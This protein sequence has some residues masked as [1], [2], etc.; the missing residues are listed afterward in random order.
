RPFR[1]LDGMSERIAAIRR[2]EN[3]AAK[4]KDACDLARRERSRSPRLDETVKAVL[5]AD[6]LDA[7]VAGG[8]DDGTDDGVQARRITAAGED[9]D[10]SDRS[11]G[12]GSESGSL[13]I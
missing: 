5:E 11:V 2:P 9:A 6:A 3:R 7:R 13:M 8:L 10:T 12:H 4:A 1:G